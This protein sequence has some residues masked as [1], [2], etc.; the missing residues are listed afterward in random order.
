M[1][2]ISHH[3]AAHALMHELLTPESI[4][5][6]DLHSHIFQWYARFDVVAGMLAGSEA[7]LSRDWYM[8]KEEHDAQLAALYPH[9]TQ[10][11]INLAGSINRRFGLDM[12]SLYA[13]LSSGMISIDEFVAQNGILGQTL[14]RMK[15]ILVAVDDP[16]HI[17]QAY[18]NQQPLTDNDP[19][20]PYVPG[21]L[22]QGP[23]W[24]LNFAWIDYLST[25]TMYLYQSFRALQQPPMFELENLALEQCRLVEAITRWPEKENGYFLSFANCL[26]IS[27]LLLP[28]DEKH[29]MWCRR[30]FIQMEQNG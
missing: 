29:I 30:K 25:K 18:P 4:N 26:G 10:Q 28:R 2:L 11:Q 23:L 8:A 17:V 19:F 12:A 14:E 3:H 13:K 21:V 1:S 16:E 15:D 22:H 6:N 7:I 24:R 5:T 9:D 27:S 20:D